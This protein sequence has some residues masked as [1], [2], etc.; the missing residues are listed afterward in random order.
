[1]YSF[2]E[3]L[4]GSPRIRMA[5]TSVNTVALTPIPRARATIATTEYQRSLTIR[6]RA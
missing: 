6:C 5:F 4:Y 3:S 1:M 2:P